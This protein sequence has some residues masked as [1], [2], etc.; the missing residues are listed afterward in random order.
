MCILMHCDAVF[1]NP[2]H[3]QA[4]HLLKLSDIFSYLPL[5]PVLDVLEG[6]AGVCAFDGPKE[7]YIG[8]VMKH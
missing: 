2:D 7:K 3:P 4:S 5:L 8:N 6:L 1:M